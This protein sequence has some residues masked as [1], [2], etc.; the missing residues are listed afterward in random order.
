M[1]ISFTVYIDL[2]SH[3]SPSFWLLGKD[4]VPLPEIPRLT[5]STNPITGESASDLILT[6][7]TRMDVLIQCTVPGEYVLVSGAGPFFTNTSGE[8]GK[9]AS[10]MIDL[11]THPLVVYKQQLFFIRQPAKLLTVNWLVALPSTTL[12]I[13]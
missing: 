2:S 1:S 7:G 12:P 4:A 11:V 9:V 8:E 3:S 13:C 5:R 6:P 10:F